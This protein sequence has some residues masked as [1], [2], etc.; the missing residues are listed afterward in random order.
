MKYMDVKSR[1]EH[2]DDLL[3][4]RR[5]LDFHVL[6]REVGDVREKLALNQKFM[7]KKMR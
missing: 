2:G 6:M 3:Q 4:K 5:N 1:E 7:T